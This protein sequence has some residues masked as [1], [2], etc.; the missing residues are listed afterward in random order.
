MGNVLTAQIPSQIL[1]ADAYLSDINDVEYVASLGSTRFM[2]IARV[3]HAEGP[4]VFKVF[5]LQDPSFSIDPYRDQVTSRCVILSRP[6]QKYTLYDR[7]STRPFLMDIE[8]RWIAYHLF[9]ALAQCEYAEVCHGDLK[10]QNILVSSYNWVQITDFASFKPASIP[11]DDPS[12]FT[13]FFDT[14]LRLSCYLAPERFCT[15]Q[16]L[17]LHP[18]LPGEFMDVSKGLTHAMDIFSLGC[19][20]VE[21]FTEGQCPFTYELLTCVQRGGTINDS[22]IQEQLPEELRSLIGLMLHRNP[23]KDQK[24]QYCDFAEPKR[25]HVG[26]TELVQEYSPLLFPPIFDHF[27][28]DYINAFRPKYIQ[29][30]MSLE[31]PQTSESVDSD[32]VIAKLSFD[33]QSNVEKLSEKAEI[34]GKPYDQ[35]SAILLIIALITSNMRTLKSL[36]AKF[37]AMKLLHKHVP[38]VDLSIVADRM[39]P[40]LVEMISDS[41]VQIR[42]EAIYSVTSL[43]KSFKEIPKYETRLFSDYLFPKLKFF[44]LD[45]NSAVR[46]TLAQNL[47]DLA[48]ASFRFIHE[49]Q[50]NLTEDLLGGSVVT[51]MDDN[52]RGEQL[53]KQEIKSTSTDCY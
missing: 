17:N 10:T 24:H 8:K 53:T 21:L 38:L 1:G 26:Y 6:Y 37:E 25:I 49:G 44:S 27:L 23:A 52:E 43:L 20:L 9:K 46:I 28:Y 16:E 15:S 45:K 19:V 13:F 32:D 33:M 51:E 2:K 18:T 5:L 50:K 31:E 40:Y 35:F 36:T 42:C 39:L 12:Y 29:T 41:M 22:K 4:S 34:N 30:S 48:E 47:G 14:S 11:S 3:N 7:L